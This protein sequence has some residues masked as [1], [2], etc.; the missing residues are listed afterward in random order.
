MFGKKKNEIVESKQQLMEL[1][2]AES[3]SV[4]EFDERSSEDIQSDSGDFM[5]LIYK[6]KK[7]IFIFM[8]HH[9]AIPPSMISMV[10]FNVSV[11]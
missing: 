7:R 9:S 3:L 10:F 11:G 6:R 1:L 2:G 8:Q 5:N 4:R